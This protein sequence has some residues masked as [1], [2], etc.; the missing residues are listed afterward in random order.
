LN[1][2]DTQVHTIALSPDGKWL[3]AADSSNSVHLWDT[4][5]NRETNVLRAQ[6]GEIRCL[7]FGPDSN[8]LAWGGLDRVIHLGDAR[9]SDDRSAA[10]DPLGSRTQLALGGGRLFSLGAG[11]DLRVWDTASGQR[12][13]ELEGGPVLRAFALSPDGRW[14]AASRAQ[15]QGADDR[16]TLGLWHADTGKAKATFDGQRAPITALAFSPDSAR[17]ASVG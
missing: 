6:A 5:R 3:A 12:T 16:G 15:E 2:H 17:L 8:L 9:S 14:V 7:A 10:A 13:L 11:T 4:T 1:S